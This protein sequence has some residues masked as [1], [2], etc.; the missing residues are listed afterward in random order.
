MRLV[1]LAWVAGVWW[2]QHASVLPGGGLFALAIGVT[3]GVFAACACWALTRATRARRDGT[4]VSVQ[5]GG[6]DHTGGGARAGN[7]LRQRCL[8][9]VLALCAGV[10]GYSWAALRADA[11]MSDRFSVQLEGR[12]LMVV[13]IV[14]E[15]P[16]STGDGLRFAL[17]VERAYVAGGAGDRCGVSSS[18]ATAATYGAGSRVDSKTGLTPCPAVHVPKHIELVWPGRSSFGRRSD[19]RIDPVEQAQRLSTQRTGPANARRP[20][21][22]ERWRLPVRLTS[23]RGFANWHGFDAELMALARGIRATGYVRASFGGSQ[24]SKAGGAQRLQSGPLPGYRFAAWRERLRDDFRA[25]LGPSARYGGVLMAL[26]LGERGDI[27]DDDWQVFS[28]TGVSHLLAISGLHVSLVAG[29]FGALVGTLWRRAC[30]RRFS[31]PLWWPAPKA[32]AIAGLLAAVA[33]G[34]V[35]GW[36]VPARRAVGMVAIVVLALLNGRFAA[37]SY[38]LMWALA[39]IVTLDPWAVVT[40]GLWLSFGAVAALVMAARRRERGQAAQRRVPFAVLWQAARAQYAVT[41]GLVPLTLAWFGAVPLLGPLA[42]AVAIPVMTLIVTPLALASLLLPATLAHWALALAHGVVVWL[43]EWLGVLAALP[44]SV[45]R[46]AVAP[47]WAQAAAVGGVIM[48]LMPLPLAVRQTWT[49][50]VGI[51]FA[52]FALMGPAWLASFP[53]PAAE[54]FRVTMLDI[55][56]GNAVLV[57]TATRTVLFDAGPPLGQRSDAGRRV[58]V[59]YLRAH[60]ISRLD[61]LVVS[62]AHDDHF[63]GALSVMKAYPDAQ[64]FSS[65][66]VTHRVRRAAGAHRTCLAGQQWTWDGVTFRFLHPDTATLREGWAGR[67]GPNG[68]SCVLRV[69]NGKYSALLAADAEAPQERAML[70]RFGERLRAD[71]LLV[72][73]HGSFTSSTAAFVAAVS[74]A[75]AVFQTGYRNRFGHPRSTVVARYRAAGARIWQTVAH[76]GIRFSITRDG[77]EPQAYREHY[78][79][80]WHEDLPDVSSLSNVPNVLN[81]PNASTTSTESELDSASRGIGGV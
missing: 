56:Q 33:Y 81:V 8:V 26:A 60:G 76:G 5:F 62:H 6:V 2:L 55:G 13:G 71:I 28:D 57:E 20:R 35:A 72:P 50:R 30:G 49:W 79:R 44:W 40:P 51:R 7:G 3:G 63:G 38:V 29:V 21:A 15:L 17:D 73:H 12:D 11:R 4:G 45:W 22:G 41:I 77:V 47:P 18:G 36:G 61:R 31:L 70:A 48:C 24:A 53:R 78:R 43:A 9:I 10:L 69:S 68:V 1:L 66:P 74:P 46:A 64:V 58:I 52:G 25:A 37:P 65:L 42:N 39:V 34:A 67:I 32:A 75:H 27:A 14:A 54:G 80:Y 59:P 23:P 16:V 19:A